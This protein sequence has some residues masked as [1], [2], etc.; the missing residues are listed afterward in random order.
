VR[1]VRIREMVNSDF[2]RKIRRNFYRVHAQFIS[3]NDKRSFC[4]Y[5]MMVCGPLTLECQVRLPEGAASAIDER[6]ALMATFTREQSQRETPA[7]ARPE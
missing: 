3:G 7:P 6:G 2:Y 1:I 5:F 4:D